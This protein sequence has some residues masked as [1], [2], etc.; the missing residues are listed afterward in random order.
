[1]L[2]E[3]FFAPVEWN[4]WMLLRCQLCRIYQPADG[5][6]YIYLAFLSRGRVHGV[7][8][9]LSGCSLGREQQRN[10]RREPVL[11]GGYL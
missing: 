7:L 2:Q 9:F 1:M 4:E 5:G 11:L 6:V 3:A 8:F 10:G